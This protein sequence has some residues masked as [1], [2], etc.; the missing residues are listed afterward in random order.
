MGRHTSD[1]AIRNR[2]RRDR[3]VDLALASDLHWRLYTPTG[4]E[5]W[6]TLA[7][8]DVYQL[9]VADCSCAFDQSQAPR[10]QSLLPL[11]PP[12]HLK[13]AL[14]QVQFVAVRDSCRT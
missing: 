8:L 11:G 9:D 13:D 10:Q 5:L 7:C 6:S 3:S 4:L 2:G 12:E 1:A 14:F